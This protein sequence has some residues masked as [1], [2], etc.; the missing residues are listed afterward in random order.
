MIIKRS[1]QNPILKPLREHGWEAEATF[2]PC[3]V[4][5]G[6]DIFLLYR[7]ISMPHYHNLAR[8][9]IITSD[10]GIAQS[11]NG[12]NFFNRRRFIVAEKDW[13]QFGCEDPRVTKLNGK[14]YIFYTALSKYPFQADGIK[15]GLAISKDLKNIQEKHLVTP[16]NAKAMALF[17][18]KINGQIWAIL[19]VHT[20]KPPTKICLASF[21]KESDIWSEKFWN[22][23]YANFEKYALPLQRNKNDFIEVGA[24]PL[25]TK[26]GWIIFYS[27]IY[28]YLSFN[29]LFGI[30]A[31]LLDLKNPSK[32]LA[33]TE[34]P[35]LTAEEYYEKIGLA[36]NVV[37]P[38]GAFIKN[39]W[40]Y[41]YY[42]G[43]DMV[44]CLTLIN[45]RIFLEE[46][47]K[48]DEKK[49]KLERF[50]HNPI[51]LPRQENSW[52]K[53]AVF[54]PGAIYLNNK[55]HLIYRAIA[56]DNVSTFGYAQSS[57]GYHIDWRSNQPIY[58]PRE[59]FEKRDNPN[60]PCGCEDPRLTKIGNKIYMGYTAYNGHIPRI[61]L[62]SI[63]VKSFLNQ[64][65]QDWAKP[66]LISPTD[67][68][69]KDMV[70]FP[71]KFQGQYLIVHRIGHD[72]DYFFS[73]NL[74]FG[75]GKWI[76]ENRWIYCRPG[77]WDSKKLGAAAPP[78][79]TKKGWI[80]FYHGVSEDNVYRV[81]AVLLD[82][83]NPIKILGRT[84][85]PLLE[86]EM[87]YEKEGLVNNVVFPCGA[88]EINGKI[89]VYYGG[90]DQVIGGATI[91]LNKLLQIFKTD[92]MY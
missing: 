91:D 82:L 29:Q 45:L 39:G 37:F 89:F 14:Y 17:P 61:A 77:W 71:E 53:K 51:L 46:I 78:L 57:N 50:S 75:E 28:N 27:Y 47:L 44:G 72:I 67:L 60:I 48:N 26:Y 64:Q 12:Y 56:E 8:N 21:N 69:D 24:P 33:R 10:I 32:I 86:P 66:I 92:K 20:D 2:N 16:F 63:N 40:I 74:N 11:K 43:A 6:K 36:P 81:G 65:W 88:V 80:L 83:K 87:P 35:I 42:G 58:I 22:N 31:V 4:V 41:L 30:E 25:K 9:N 19:N 68:N 55:V 59:S 90:A 3:P 85:K 1:P 23:W 84:S 18:E 15:V 52:E 70:I 7:A 73:K 62:T 38:S 34:C 49:P 5:K 76:E 13:E 79:K 54:N